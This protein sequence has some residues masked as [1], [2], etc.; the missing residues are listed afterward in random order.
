M[1]LK[2]PPLRPP[3]WIF[4]PV[5]TS[6]YLLMGYAA[7][8]AWTVG[9]SS[10]NPRVIE[11]T[12]R[13]ATLYTVQLV[14]NQIYMPLLFGLGRPVE[15]LVD[16]VALTG[17]VGYLAWIWKGVD[18]TAAWCMVPYLAWLGFA[19]YLT[20]ATEMSQAMATDQNC[21]RPPSAPCFTTRS[22]FYA[23]H[24]HLSLKREPSK[25]QFTGS[26]I[27]L[28]STVSKQS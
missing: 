16:V 10:M 17:S 11:D 27:P 19:T 5:W 23:A 3:P 26:T 24:F 13:G 1:T 12:R 7:H 14:L 22:K 18:E 4:A 20:A 9:F 8:R 28:L 6:L 25:S 21:R 2:Q 15:A